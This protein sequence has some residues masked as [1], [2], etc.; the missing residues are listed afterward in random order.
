MLYRIDLSFKFRT[1]NHNF[2]S[3]IYL[4]SHV[5]SL[6]TSFPV[7]KNWTWSWWI[8]VLTDSCSFFSLL[9]LLFHSL[10]MITTLVQRC[11]RHSSCQSLCFQLVYSPYLPTSNL[12]SYLPSFQPLWSLSASLQ[13]PKRPQHAARELQGVE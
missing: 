5:L 1:S 7:L 2:L 9:L 4:L 6:F 13:P 3:L 10:C 8:I 12:L 11:S